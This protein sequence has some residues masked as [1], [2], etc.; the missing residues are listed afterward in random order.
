VVTGLI[1]GLGYLAGAVWWTAYRR[2]QW[3]RWTR[4]CDECVKYLCEDHDNQ[5]D[6]YMI[7]TCFGAIV[8]FVALPIALWTDRLIAK[9]RAEEKA[10]A[11]AER[12]ESE[13][14]RLLK[15]S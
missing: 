15:E 5:K 11:E 2:A 14:D 3:F 8:W 10:E 6:D 13:M 7:G 9:D 4:K 1:L 12:L